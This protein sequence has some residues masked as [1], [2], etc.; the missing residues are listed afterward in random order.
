MA[1]ALLSPV[2]GAIMRTTLIQDSPRGRAPSRDDPMTDEND[3]KWKLYE[4]TFIALMWDWAAAEKASN[5]QVFDQY[6]TDPGPGLDMHEQAQL[7]LEVVTDPYIQ[8]PELLKVIGVVLQR[9]RIQMNDPDWESLP[10]VSD[11]PL[12]IPVTEPEAWALFGAA[13]HRWLFTMLYHWR[14]YFGSRIPAK[15]ELFS[16]NSGRSVG[17]KW[18]LEAQ[19]R[20]SVQ[21]FRQRVAQVAQQLSHAQGIALGSENS[22]TSAPADSTM[23]GHQPGDF[24]QAYGNAPQPDMRQPTAAEIIESF[25]DVYRAYDSQH[26]SDAARPGNDP[27]SPGGTPGP[28]RKK[29]MTDADKARQDAESQDPQGQR[30]RKDPGPPPPPVG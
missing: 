13:G 10:S 22:P 2:S 25:A 18:T 15:L 9:N 11:N 30:R 24:D 6:G 29:Q 16:T 12:T 14:V 26:Q 1:Q 21:V 4:G 19:N 23:H 7:S 3:A 27:T 17:I 8:D 20:Q 28:Q 5:L